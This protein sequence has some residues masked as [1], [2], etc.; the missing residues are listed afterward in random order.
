MSVSEE[1]AKTAEIRTSQSKSILDLIDHTPEFPFEEDIINF[2][3]AFTHTGDNDFLSTILFKPA[4]TSG[5]VRFE[6]INI[7]QLESVGIADETVS[8]DRDDFPLLKGFEHVVEF[9][10]EGSVYNST[11]YGIQGNSAYKENDRVALELNMDSDPRTLTFFVNNKE[12]PN[13]IFNV[14]EEV[15]FFPN[16]LLLFV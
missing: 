16:I 5:I 15:K 13:Y 2:D 8:Y 3:D 7:K 6:V 11:D 12:Q 10:A 1:L 4:I 9:V 14:P